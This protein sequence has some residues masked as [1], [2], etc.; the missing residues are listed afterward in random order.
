MASST[1][2]V[3]TGQTETKSSAAELSKD[4]AIKAIFFLRFS[5]LATLSLVPSGDLISD[6][7][8]H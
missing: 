4:S 7:P 1:S 6:V 5:L 8:H 2:L 3:K